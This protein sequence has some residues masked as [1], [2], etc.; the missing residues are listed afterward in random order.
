MN[1]HNRSCF[2]ATIMPFPKIPKRRRKNHSNKPGRPIVHK[3]R[4]GYIINTPFLYEYK[5][6]IKRPTLKKGIA[7]AP[8]HSLTV[9]EI[10]E[11]LQRK[12]ELILRYKFPLSFAF[13]RLYLEDQYLPDDAIVDVSK[14]GDRKFTLLAPKDLE[15]ARV[16]VLFSKT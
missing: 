9:L 5:G 2:V 14:D 6:F 11:M 16:L 13:Y 3:R 8:K 1:C 10:K 4:K 15:T 12:C 7:I